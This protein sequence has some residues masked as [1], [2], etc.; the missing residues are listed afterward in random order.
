VSKPSNLQIVVREKGGGPLLLS[1]K[2]GEERAKLRP[3]VRTTKE[4][5][6]IRAGQFRKGEGHRPN[7][8]M[9]LSHFSSGP[10]RKN[11]ESGC[12]LGKTK[13]VEI[14]VL[15]CLG[16]GGKSVLGL[17]VDQRNILYG[18]KVKG[19]LAEGG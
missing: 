9:V 12:G 7:L 6:K 14:V 13:K 19:N 8:R 16:R 10:R 18:G 4:G 1:R 2:G 3:L 5:E 15:N 17:P 11:F